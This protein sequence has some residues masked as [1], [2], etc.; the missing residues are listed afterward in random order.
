MFTQPEMSPTTLAGVDPPDLVSVKVNVPA[1][2]RVEGVGQHSSL[3]IERFAIT[4][5]PEGEQTY[6]LSI[7]KETL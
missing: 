1:M 3:P 7:K 5:V 2:E 4:V 6:K